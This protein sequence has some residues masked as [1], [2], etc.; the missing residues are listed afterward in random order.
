MSESIFRALKNLSYR[1]K[2]L[3]PQK[4]GHFWK[5]IEG[6]LFIAHIAIMLF[7]VA[8]I[9]MYYLTRIDTFKFLSLI[10]YGFSYIS[11]FFSPIASIIINR[12]KISYFIGNPTATFLDDAKNKS[13]LRR[14]YISFL[15]TKKTS[16][17]KIALIHLQE[18]KSCLEKRTSSLIGN[19][20]NFGLFPGLIALVISSSQFNNSKYDWLLVVIAST[21]ILYFFAFIMNLIAL[22]QDSY[23]RLLKFVIEDHKVN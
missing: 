5:S 19:I 20:N 18:V 12:K 16:E 8:S 21:S 13:K 7:C 4:A 11:Y 9:G 14:R 2:D 6:K 1:E 3:I 10:S 23:I 22:K 15:Q 17:L